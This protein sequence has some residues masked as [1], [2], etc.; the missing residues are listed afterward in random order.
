MKILSNKKM[1]CC[2]RPVKKDMDIEILIKEINEL[3]DQIKVLNN[4]MVK[5]T[6]KF[7]ELKFRLNKL[8]RLQFYRGENKVYWNSY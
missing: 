7:M 3:K 8:L 2:S 1:F 6:E 5:H 4:A